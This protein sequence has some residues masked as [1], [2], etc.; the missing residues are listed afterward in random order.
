MPSLRDYHSIAFI[1]GTIH[2][3]IDRVYLQLPDG[4]PPLT[5]LKA[6]QSEQ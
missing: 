6:S 2:Q 3:T 1:L 4:N 5:E